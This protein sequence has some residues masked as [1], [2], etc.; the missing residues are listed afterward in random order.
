MV[1]LGPEA[2][3]DPGYVASLA[4]N[5]VDIV[6]IN[7]GHDD[8]ETWR[9]MIDNTRA[10]SSG[11]PLRV[12]MDIA[13][14]KVRM[15]E[16]ATPPDRKRLVVGDRILLCRHIDASAADVPFRA[17]CAP[18]GVLDRLTVGDAVSIDDGKLHGAIVAA[19]DGG[20][21]VEVT[22][23]RLKGVKLKPGRG[24]NFPAVDLDLAPLT[25]KDHRDL[26]FVC[27]NADLI[28]HSFVQ[29]ANDVAVLQAELA[30]RRADWQ[31]IGLVAKIETPV[32]VANLPEIIVQAA[33]AQPLF[34]RRS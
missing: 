1:T 13:G 25:D 31:R 5:G 30:A 15:D 6:R 20:F 28:G 12:L 9:R 22:D 34:R 2:A 3:D 7:C 19:A 18:P 27:A 23:G 8:A 29:S 24:L 14:P 32:A 33:G 10:A 16:T 17:T 21:V 4:E 11:H 26:D